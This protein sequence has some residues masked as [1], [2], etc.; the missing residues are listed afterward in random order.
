MEAPHDSTKSKTDVFN[1]S[2][3][4]S[5]ML[6]AMKAAGMSVPEAQEVRKS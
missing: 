3:S 4:A 1:F 2:G 6:A 5:D